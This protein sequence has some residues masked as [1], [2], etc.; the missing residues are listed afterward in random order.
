LGFRPRV[1]LAEGLK[2]TLERDE[3]FVKA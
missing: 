3:R 1:T 2:L